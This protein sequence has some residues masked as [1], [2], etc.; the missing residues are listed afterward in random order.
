MAYS[1]LMTIP[2][3]SFAP[4]WGAPYG[5][6]YLG[7]WGP[8][9]RQRLALRFSGV[10]D[11]VDTAYLRNQRPKVPGGAWPEGAPGG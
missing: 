3:R 7:H 11:F 10:A 1:V 4:L 6:I 8:V 5:G 2:C 9:Y